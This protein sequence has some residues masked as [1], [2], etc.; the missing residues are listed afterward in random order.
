MSKENTKHILNNVFGLTGTNNKS[1]RK[2]FDTPITSCA[3]D[4]TGGKEIKNGKRN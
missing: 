4:F 1:L 2:L 3:I